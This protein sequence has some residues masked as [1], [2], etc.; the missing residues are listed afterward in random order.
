M[1]NV[2]SWS[3]G[4]FFTKTLGISLGFSKQFG[5]QSSCRF[6]AMCQSILEAKLLVCAW[7]NSDRSSEAMLPTIASD[8]GSDHPDQFW[9]PGFRN[10]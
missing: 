3:D 1:V 4:D 5:M 10:P 6:Q 8:I 7:V 2:Y 9:Q